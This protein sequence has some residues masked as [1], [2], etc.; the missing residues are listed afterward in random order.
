MTG[1]I[2]ELT[3][4]R[5]KL[6]LAII[7]IFAVAAAVYGRSVEHHLKAAGFTDSSSE[8]ERARDLL[9]D[10]LGYDAS[11]GIVLVVRD[12]RGGALA[13]TDPEVRAEVNRLAGELAETRYVGEVVNPLTGPRKSDPSSS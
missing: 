3:W 7:G 6:V 4:R 11:A 8:S 13:L 9:Q 1:R 2:A 5:P 12:P 10:R